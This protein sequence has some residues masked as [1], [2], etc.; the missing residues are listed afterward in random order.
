VD[1]DDPLTLPVT[2]VGDALSPRFSHTCRRAIY[3]HE[4]RSEDTASAPQRA[5]ALDDLLSVP[6]D[7]PVLH[8]SFRQGA[9]R[10]NLILPIDY[11]ATPISPT[12]IANIN[13]TNNIDAYT[14]RHAP[15]I[16]VLLEAATALTHCVKTR[17]LPIS[18]TAQS[19][20][21][22]IRSI[23]QRA[24]SG[25][26]K[27]ATCHFEG[28][29]SSYGRRTGWEGSPGRMATGFIIRPSPI[30]QPLADPTPKKAHESSFHPS[31]SVGD[32]VTASRKSHATHR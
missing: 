14:R 13:L 26:L 3:L 22:I 24:H 20:S 8:L 27:S 12:A 32:G 30:E 17:P 11:Y 10:Y 18:G 7:V 15:D 19:S 9:A 25:P 6:G 16:H 4:I 1:L 21:K 29:G 23:V 5:G 31:T 28:E 2:G